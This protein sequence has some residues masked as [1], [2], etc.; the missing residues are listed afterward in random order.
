MNKGFVKLGVLFGFIA[1]V[2]VGTVLFL[3]RPTVKPAEATFNFPPPVYKD[4]PQPVCE[5][6]QINFHDD[7]KFTVKILGVN[8]SHRWHLESNTNNTATYQLQ[9]D[10]DPTPGVKWVDVKGKTQVVEY[11][12]CPPVNPCDPTPSIYILSK[13]DV[14]VDVDPCVTPSP[15]PEPTPGNPGNP[16][17]FAGSSTNAP[18]CT[19][20]NTVQLPANPHVYRNGESATVNFFITQGD[21]ANVYWRV[22]GQKDWQNALSDLKPN[23]DHFVSVTIHGLDPKLGYDFGIQQVQGCGGG[24]LVTAVIVDGPKPV[25]F[26]FSYWEW[27]K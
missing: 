7:E 1:L 5:N 16:P 17:T 8:V 6:G 18:V 2:L 11:T 4:A 19:D 15:S 10:A 21:S 27:S 23:A 24:Q 20:G 26:K 12:P 13:D 22:V 14:K 3:N 25:L 9:L